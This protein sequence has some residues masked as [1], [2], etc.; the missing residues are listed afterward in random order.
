MDIILH[1]L[2]AAVAFYLGGALLNGVQIK[3]FWQCVIVAIVVALLNVTL[4]TFLKVITLGLLGFGI[5]SWLLN[6]IL[7][8]VAD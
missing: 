8:Q 6:A 7:I 1:I 3:N 4:G 5:F 2:V